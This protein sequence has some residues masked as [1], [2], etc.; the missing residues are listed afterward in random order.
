MCVPVLYIAFYH[1]N[2]CAHTHSYIYIWG[3]EREKNEKWNSELV[4]AIILELL[5]LAILASLFCTDHT[6]YWKNKGRVRGKKKRVEKS[7][8]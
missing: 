4:L 6:Y 7:H 2:I 3:G 1:I 5:S 8:C